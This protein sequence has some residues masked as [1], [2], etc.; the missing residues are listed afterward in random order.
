MEDNIPL[1]TKLSIDVLV[2]NSSFKGHFLAE[3]GLSILIDAET[4]D[5]KKFKLL[6]DTGS[7]GST[8][9]HN[10]KRLNKD[11]SNLDAIVLSHGHYDHTGGLMAVFNLI[12]HKIPIYLH[13]HALNQKFSERNEKLRSIGMPDPILEKIESFGDLKISTEPQYIHHSIFTTGQVERI[14]PFEKVSVRF[15]QKVSRE[16]EHDDI[17]DDQSLIIKMKTGIIIISGCGHS[18]IVNIIKK[19]I[20][21]SGLDHINLILGGFHLINAN[22]DVL[23]S[24]INELKKVD[25]GLIGPNHCTGLYPTTLII[26]EYQDKFREMHVGDK[27]LLGS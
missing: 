22:L 1:V 10:L 24:T 12:N 15:R 16:I 18:G 3:H 11:I 27:I 6:F 14:T 4:E 9:V 26:N 20:K 17:L 19:A 13:P 21:I 5:N 7:S 23:E 25:I 8:L 2:E